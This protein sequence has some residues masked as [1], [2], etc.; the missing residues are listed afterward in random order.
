MSQSSQLI[1]TLKRELRQQRITYK[2]VAAALELSEPSIKRLFAGRFFT[3]ER[4]EK[5]C[6]L[7]GIGFNDLVQ[8]MEKNVE[9]TSQLT[10][11]QEREL[12]SDNKLLVLAYLLVNGLDFASVVAEYEI[13]ETE[14]IRLLARLDRMKIIELLPGNRVRLLIAPNFDWIPNGPI[15]RFFEAEIQTEF[16]DTKFDGPRQTVELAPFFMGKYEVTQSQWAR[17]NPGLPVSYYE[18]GSKGGERT[19]QEITGLNP[20]ESVTVRLPVAHSIRG[21]R[22]LKSKLY[23][24]WMRAGLPVPA[25]QPSSCTS[26]RDGSSAANRSDSSIFPCKRP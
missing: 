10:L 3:L 7:L 9:L 17:W 11:E 18:L 8:Q 6:D 20:V 4:L 15:Q 12:I 14:G 5:I 26:A 24:S 22:M 2:Q 19:E 1:D 13:E 16:F 23:R 21:P 25:F